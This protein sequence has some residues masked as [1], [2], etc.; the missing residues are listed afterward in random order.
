MACIPGRLS[1]LKVSFDNGATFA[2]LGALVDATLNLNVDELECTTHDS[3][4][5]RAFIPNHTDATID[6]VTRWD[7]DDPQQVQLLFTLFPNPSE[8]KIQFMMEELA[9]RRRFDADAFLTN[10]SPT[11][12]LDGTVDADF[13]MRL[14]NIVLAVQ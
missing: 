1:R 6:G 9:G 11:T 7:E 8:F 5:I 2:N 14:S 4:G 13:A 12:P 3:N 10:L